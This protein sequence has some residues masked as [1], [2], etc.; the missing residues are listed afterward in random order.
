M[1]LCKTLKFQ[2]YF[3]E[4]R[5]FQYL[6]KTS[7]V[8]VKA[9]GSI[10]TGRTMNLGISTFQGFLFSHDFKISHDFPMVVFDEKF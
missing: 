10:P 7:T 4:A 9:V 8:D 2:H 6:T 1:N 3:E 5:I